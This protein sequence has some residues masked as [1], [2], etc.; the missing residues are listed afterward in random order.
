V[1]TDDEAVA[2]GHRGL[3]ARWQATY[4]GLADPPRKNCWTIAEHTG[5]ASPDGLQHLL[6]RARW[7][8]DLGGT[9]CAPSCWTTWPTTA[10]LPMD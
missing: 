4:E 7:D 2:E 1:L 9:T 3:P 10:P 5:D 8:A 6:G